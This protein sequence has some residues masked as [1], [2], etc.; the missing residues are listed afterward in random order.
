MWGMV[1]QE[2][3]LDRPGSL[4]LDAPG[5]GHPWTWTPL[6]LDTP[7]PGRTG[8]VDPDCGTPVV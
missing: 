8:V 3:S 6:D 5:P 1:R 4:D 7:R 2:S